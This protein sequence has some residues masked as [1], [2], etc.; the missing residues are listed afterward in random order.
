MQSGLVG[1]GGRADVGLVRRRREVDD[2][3]DRVRDAGHLGERALG[4]HLPV[5]LQLQG[6]DD[7]EEVGV[8]DPLAVAVGAAWTCV[9]PASTAAR[10]LATAQPVSSWAWMPSAGA[11]VGE[12]VETTAWTW[13]GSM[14]PLV[15]Q[16]MTTSAPASAA[17]RDG[18]RG[19]RGVGAVAVEEVLA[20]DEDA[21]ALV[22]QVGD[23]VA[24]HLQ[25]LVERGAQGELHVAVVRLGDERDHA[26]AGLAAGL[27]L[28]V[29]GR[30]DA[31]PAGRAE[32]DELGVPEVELL[33]G[34]AEE[35]GVP[36]VGA[37]PAALDEA[38]AEVVEVPR[39][40][41]ACPRPRG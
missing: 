27:H 3:G 2:L 4:E 19:V 30:R 6:G 17:V 10:V 15:S 33:A 35:L 32:G 21:A 1:E 24:D 25:V 18:P 26:G 37:R 12:D 41:S 29:L 39:D 28:R 23:G 14:P 34:A 36:G 31:G 8:A 9:A 11:G 7:G 40:A 38:H 13:A 22:A 20:V 16:R 5:V